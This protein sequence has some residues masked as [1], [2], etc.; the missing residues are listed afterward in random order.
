VGWVLLLP[1]HLWQVL[2][3]LVELMVESLEHFCWPTGL[4]KVLWKLC[5]S[6]KVLQLERRC[7]QRESRKQVV[8]AS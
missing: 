2:V 3:D 6:P 1:G 7:S 4:A 8:N 5:L